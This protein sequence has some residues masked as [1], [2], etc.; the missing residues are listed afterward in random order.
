MNAC[1][2]SVND[3]SYN[4]NAFVE[5]ENPEYESLNG[6]NGKSAKHHNDIIYWMNKFKI[7]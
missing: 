2:Q 1:F 7:N 3:A 6:M 5:I 4:Y